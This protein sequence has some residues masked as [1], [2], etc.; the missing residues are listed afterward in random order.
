MI[1]FIGAGP[2]A[3]DLL[4]LRAAER[5]AAADVV[6]WAA[7]L[8]AEE[9]LDGCRD[10]VVLHDS[11]GM[12]LEEVTAVFEAHPDAAIV[13]LHS[14]DPTIYSAVA[15]Q[16]DWCRRHRRDFEI[17]PGVSS[18]TATAAA[19][20]RELT[21]PG[22]SQTVVL[23]RLAHR[24]A[25]SVPARESV[26][27]MARRGATMALYL[28]AA[29]PE[30]LREELL[31]DGSAYTPDTP[32]VIGYR[33]SW[34]EQEIVV[35]TVGSLVEDLA[36]LGRTMSVLIL[37]GD[38]LADAEVPARSHVYFGGYAHTYRA[39][40]EPDR[41]PEGRLSPAGPTEPPG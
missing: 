38:A 21:V 20:G 1:S 6:V 9:V 35:S 36:A 4:T 15:E 13:R 18:A 14:G 7:S 33:V 30:A 27:E 11:A 16:V 37:V 10:D 26:A 29:R 25:T 17:V 24:T 32:A 41:Q 19:V 31:C 40:G 2:G 8:V 22:R 28:S 39:A 12:T 3:A 5:L 23:T 34:P